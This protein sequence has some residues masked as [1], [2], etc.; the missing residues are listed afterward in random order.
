[1]RRE[2]EM[3]TKLSNKEPLEHYVQQDY[4]I[5]LV[6][7]E[8]TWLAS[9][10]D[11]PG[12][13]SYGDTASEAVENVTKVKELW[14]KGRYESDQPIPEPTEEDDFSGRFVLRIP[15][16]LHRSLA[17]HAQKQGVS[18]NHYISHLLS[19]RHTGVQFQDMAKSFFDLC[20]HRAQGFS[21]RWVFH[22][23][24]RDAVVIAGN[25]HG[26]YQ[27]LAC[28]RKPPS[29]GSMRVRTKDLRPGEGKFLPGFGG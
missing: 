16:G 22:H 26:Q 4:P 9:L 20:T 7:D 5:E 13:N 2:M 18:L 24:Q 10:P 8:G 23:Y 28:I 27:F 3:S 21:R 12:C 29:E 25:L 11:L 1:M 14:I 15:K 6:R 17:F 19:E